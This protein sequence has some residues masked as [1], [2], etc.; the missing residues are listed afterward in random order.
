MLRQQ[1]NKRKSRRQPLRRTAEVSLGANERPILC[2]IWDMS[3]GG[4]RLATARPLLNLPPRF[5]L[6]LDDNGK[7]QRQCEVVWTDARYVGVKFIISDER[8]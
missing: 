4:A 2:V 5:T 3:E 8:P 6:S 7:V 1:A